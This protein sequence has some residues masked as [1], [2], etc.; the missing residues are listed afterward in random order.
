MRRLNG[1]QLGTVGGDNLSELGEWL[2]NRPEILG[3]TL[4]IIID[5]R[6][7]AEEESE[8]E[9]MTVGGGER[10]ESRLTATDFFDLLWK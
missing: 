10:E 1:H 7:T 9:D 3:E 5:L 8:A 6:T 4:M 2:T